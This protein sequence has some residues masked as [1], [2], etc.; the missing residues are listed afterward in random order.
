MKHA[1][2]IVG[3]MV[4]A[5][6]ALPVAASTEASPDVRSQIVVL[7][8]RRVAAEQQI[9]ALQAEV[10]QS[11]KE[12]SSPT[13]DFNSQYWSDSAQVTLAPTSSAQQLATSTTTTTTTTGQPASRPRS[14]VGSCI[15]YHTTY[16]NAATTWCSTQPGAG[17]VCPL[18]LG[19]SQWTCSNGQW[20]QSQ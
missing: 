5:A 1:K 11:Q 4:A 19:F 3:L 18:G 10:A 7:I 8:Q 9:S 2:T 17:R 13:S 20:V 16:L 6:Q 14:T 15:A 12:E